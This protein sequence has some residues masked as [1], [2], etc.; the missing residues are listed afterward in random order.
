MAKLQTCVKLYLQKLVQGKWSDGSNSIDSN[1]EF[2]GRDLNRL[3][4]SI[5]FL[6]EV[7]NLKTISAINCVANLKKWY[8]VKHIID[9]DQEGFLSWVR[10]S[11]SVSR[12]RIRRTQDQSR[13]TYPQPYDR[14]CLSSNCAVWQEQIWWSSFPNPHAGSSCNMRRSCPGICFGYP[15]KNAEGWRNN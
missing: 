13:W 10:F 8:H 5:L 9:Q 3:K 12:R 4:G 2:A 7:I 14:T 15:E 1:W 11:H 6:F